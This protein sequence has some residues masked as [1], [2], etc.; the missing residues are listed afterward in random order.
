MVVMMNSGLDWGAYK[1]SDESVKP[2]SIS[3]CLPTPAYSGCCASGMCVRAVPCQGNE[4][5]IKQERCNV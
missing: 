2:L 1:V 4:K 3:T 5:G